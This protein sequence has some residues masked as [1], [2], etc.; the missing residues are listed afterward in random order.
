VALLGLVALLVAG[1]VELSAESDCPSAEAVANELRAIAGD[2]E[3]TGERVVI[4]T[5]A[6]GVAL[7]LTG[8]DGTLLAERVLPAGD[9]AELARAAAVLIAA[10]RTEVR[11]TAPRLVLPPPKQPVPIGFELG[12]GFTAAL[13][14]G[15]TNDL[16]AAGGTLA[17]SV[18]PRRGRLL[19][20]LAVTGL[21]LRS[22][23]V[24]TTTGAHARFTRAGLSAGPLVRFRPGRF[25]LDLFAELTAALV[26]AD[27]LGFPVNASSVGFDV[28]LGG[29]A[30][31]A[32]RA[33]PVA[34]FLGV[35]V[36]GWLT[37]QS[38]QVNGAAGGKADL[39]RVDILLEAG[40][41][42]GKY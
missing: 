12:A 21:A 2:A 9:C 29:G 19:A 34:P 14:P 36:A 33:G 11:P 26:Y 20:R 5:D 42:F 30:R 10:W 16:F 15:S 38:V 24:G 35:R 41:S 17:A 6:R 27:A 39:P 40:I 22:L 31:A 7:R 28:G 32:I 8:R 1:G 3:A 4:V 23:A 13:A 25:L 18:G 37:P